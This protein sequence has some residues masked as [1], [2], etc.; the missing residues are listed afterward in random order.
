[1][2]LKYLSKKELAPV[3]PI[4]V[5]TVLQVYLDLRIPG[6]MEQITNA[7]QMGPASA[8]VQEYGLRMLLCAFLSLACGIVTGYLAAR[9]AA[10]LARILRARQFDRVESYSKEDVGKFSAASLITRSTNDVYHIQLVIARQLPNVIRAPVMAVWAIV[11]IAGKN[12]EWTAATA[13]AVL[14]L[15][16]VVTFTVVRSV[17]RFRKVQWLTDGINRTTMGEL[18]GVR[19]I[20]SYNAEG[21]EEQK[22]SRANDALLENSLGTVRIMAPMIPVVSSLNNFLT[23]AIY[24]IGAGIIQSTAALDGKMFL[25]SDMV[26]FSSYAMKIISSFMMMSGFVRSLPRATVAAKRIEEV[27]STAPS[28]TDGSGNTV[29]IPTGLIFD[30]VSFCYP[31]TDRKVLDDVNFRV[32][33]GETVAVIG[34]TGSGKTSLISLIPRFYDVTDGRITLDGTDLRNYCLDDLRSRLGYVPQEPTIFSGTVRYNVNYGAGAADRT[35]ADIWR[36]LQV[37]QAADFVRRT[38]HGLDTE[39]SQYGRNLSGGQKQRICIARAVCR[40]PRL[41]L[42]DD[43]FSALDFRTDRA[44]RA[45][46]RQ[47]TAGRSVLLVSQRIGTIMDADRI[48]VLEHGRV[49]GM[50]THQELLRHCAVYRELARTQLGVEAVP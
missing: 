37:A 24:W 46:L 9:T 40:A 21:Y 8:V 50:G 28:V 3:I 36:A 1:M 41:Y 39:I 6:Y 43:S 35:E 29:G 47:E 18:V 34:S 45:A 5:L 14:V 22:F 19:E 23:L 13:A 17:P 33:P 11:M 42:L 25:F 49:V 32:G 20:R 7:L 27:I 2:I 16:A 30:H 44:L 48:V 15:L 26:V 38:E 12:W 10:S 31:G 4:A